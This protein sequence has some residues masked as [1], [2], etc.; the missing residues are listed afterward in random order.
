MWSDAVIE[1]IIRGI[2]ETLY[3]S[4]TSTAI[5]YVLGIPMGIILTVTDREG[6]HPNGFVY[7]ILDFIVNIV[8]S[9]PFLIGLMLLIPVTRMIVGKSYG[10]TATIVPLVFAATPFIARLVESSLK[11]VDPGVIEAAKAMGQAI[12][13]LLPGCFWWRQEPPCSPVL[14]LHSERFLVIPLW[15]ES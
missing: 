1:M 7:K 10:S 14:P 3:M 4:L 5:G 9:I 15:L 12:S 13:P 2:G 8:R 6:I 11:E